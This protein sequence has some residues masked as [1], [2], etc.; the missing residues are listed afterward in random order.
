MLTL[1]GRPAT[2][3]RP[4]PSGHNYKLIKWVFAANTT[5]L[6]NLFD[7][8]LCLGP[9]KMEDSHHRGRSETRQRRLQPPE[10]LPPHCSTRVPQ[11][12]LGENRRQTP[13]P[14]HY[15]ITPKPDNVVWR[16]SVLLYDRCGLCPTHDVETA[17]APGGVCSSLRFDIQGFFDNVNHGRLTA[18][19]ESL[20]FPQKYASG[21]S[22]SSKTGPFASAST[23]SRQMKSTSRWGHL[24]VLRCPRPLSSPS[25]TLPQSSTLRNDGPMRQA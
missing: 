14:R 21:L 22:L 23:V 9:K 20:D 4:G 19:I 17:H 11:Q 6:H 5:R 13:Y 10:M 8:C 24:K 1:L 7:A 18:L 12:T 3:P 15:L 2:S 16:V 25:Y